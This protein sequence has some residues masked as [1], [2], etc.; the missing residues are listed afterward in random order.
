M[1]PNCCYSKQRH[2]ARL[3]FPCP[4]VIHERGA[5]AG[6]KLRSCN[7]FRR[8][9]TD[10]GAARDENA[11]AQANAE[12]KNLGTDVLWK[13][14]IG[15]IKP[16]VCRAGAG[17][18]GKSGCELKLKARLN[19]P[20]IGT[21]SFLRMANLCSYGKRAWPDKGCRRARCGPRQLRL[22]R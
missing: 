9:T 1:K 12:N 15:K 11:A 10:G 4:P 22:G 3:K 21:L 17:G 2:K 5:S 13:H 14:V 20:N 18:L 6:E 19:L 7:C 16:P 8:E